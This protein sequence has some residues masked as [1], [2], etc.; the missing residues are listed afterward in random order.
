M[1]STLFFLN[2]DLQSTPNEAYK[3][4]VKYTELLISVERTMVYQYSLKT[5][6]SFTWHFADNTK[7]MQHILLAFQ[8]FRPN[9]QQV[10]FDLCLKVARCCRSG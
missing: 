9:E 4:Q 6:H 2:L 7:Y 3:G 1:K 5:I 8:S 10:N